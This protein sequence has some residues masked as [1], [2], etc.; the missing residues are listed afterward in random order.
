MSFSHRTINFM[1][2]INIF[3]NCLFCAR[4]NRLISLIEW[5]N[6]F[7][8]N[9]TQLL[10]EFHATNS[11]TVLN[12]IND[13]QKVNPQGSIKPTRCNIWL[14]KIKSFVLYRTRLSA[15]SVCNFLAFNSSV[16]NV[17]IFKCLYCIMPPWRNK[18]V[19]TLVWTKSDHKKPSQKWIILK[20]EQT[21]QFV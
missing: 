13:W 11:K 4:M 19:C 2:M 16:F 5:L 7:N 10:S 1:N 12:L 14:D 3:R 20:R 15:Q 21:L 8:L 17:C 18:D 6:N 9:V